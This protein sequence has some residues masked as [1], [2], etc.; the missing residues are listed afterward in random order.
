M[1]FCYNLLLV[2]F[3]CKSA[4]AQH[5]F[6]ADGAYTTPR[7]FFAGLAVGCNITQVDGDGYSGYHKIGLNLGPVV[8]A[9]FSDRFGASIAINFSQKGA[10]S[11]NYTENSF[12][13]GYVDDY[14][15]KLNYIEV[16]LLLHVFTDNRIN[17]G[18]GA[19]YARLI[20]AKERAVTYAQV[21]ID[22]NIY[23]FRKNDF[24]VMGEL[25]YM[26]YKGWFIGAR[27]AYS[28]ASIRD[29][30]KIP[31]GYGGGRFTR[32]FNNIFNFK[33]IYLIH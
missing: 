21:N 30:D 32:Q 19:S 33:L 11:K 15:I 9:R 3:F 25:N 16:P 2:L 24:N 1:R 28:I 8:Y 13:I 12:G 17:V 14:S 31:L 29:A 6:F 27:Y 26:F 4:F 7:T 23:P 18:V 22:P 5:N 10:I 20:S